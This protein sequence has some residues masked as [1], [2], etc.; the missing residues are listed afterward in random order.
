MWVQAPLSKTLV[1]RL[2]TYNWALTKTGTKYNIQWLLPMPIE[3]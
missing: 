2:T 3:N 1:A